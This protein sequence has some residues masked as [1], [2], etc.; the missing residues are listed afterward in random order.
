MLTLKE[1]LEFCDLIEEESNAITDELGS[2][3]LQSTEGIAL[4]KR[5][6]GSPNISRNRYG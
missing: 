3:L 5:S 4:I 1:C 2:C 6:L